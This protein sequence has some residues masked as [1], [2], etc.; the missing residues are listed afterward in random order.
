MLK[1]LEELEKNLLPT[2]GVTAQPL[3]DDLFQWHANIRGP[4]GTPFEGGIFHLEI[5]I[6]E[7]YPHN[8][9]IINLPVTLPHPNV[10]G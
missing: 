4:E 9:P 6:P 5:T 2:V 10:F 7:T 1:D 8:P 3:E